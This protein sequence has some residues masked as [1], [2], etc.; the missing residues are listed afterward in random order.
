[1]CGRYT[2]YVDDGELE[3]LEMLDI[4]EAR[5]RGKAGI[6]FK[7]GEI[8]PS[9]RV[10][11][12][13]QGNN[14]GANLA[15]SNWGFKIRDSLVINARSETAAEKPSF[16]ESWFSS[17]CIVPS[18]GFFEW[19]SCKTKYRFNLPDT[20]MLYMAGLMRKAAGQSEF[21]ILTADANESVAPV[22]PRM[23]VILT[24]SDFPMWLG[25]R[26]GGCEGRAAFLEK[27]LAKNF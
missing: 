9:D 4:M 14:G 21:V 11:V 16:R 3:L 12:I 8:F 2:L 17:R 24:R 22:H 25:G 18:T 1:M 20:K 23:P 19:D 7:T 27:S 5:G 13:T 6:D 15:V 26:D 10:P